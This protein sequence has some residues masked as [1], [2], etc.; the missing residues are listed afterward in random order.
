MGLRNFFSEYFKV[1]SAT[2]SPKRAIMASLVLA[3]ELSDVLLP[4]LGIDKYS[5]YFG[6]SQ[7][8]YSTADDPYET[9]L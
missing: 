1:K 4:E 2:N 8:P 3:A 9:E 6:Q 7:W 5:F